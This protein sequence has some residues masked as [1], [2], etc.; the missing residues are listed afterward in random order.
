[1]NASSAHRA[2]YS[3][4]A[5]L[6]RRSMIHGGP[7]DIISKALGTVVA[8]IKRVAANLWRIEGDDGQAIEGPRRNHLV[9]EYVSANEKFTAL[10]LTRG[11]DVAEVDTRAEGVITLEQDANKNCWLALCTLSRT[12]SHGPIERE[13]IEAHN[14]RTKRTRNKRTRRYANLGEMAWVV[15]D[16][17][18]GIYAAKTGGDIS[19]KK[20]IVHPTLYARIQ[21]G[22]IIETTRD[23]DAAIKWMSEGLTE[24]DVIAALRGFNGEIVSE[25]TVLA[26]LNVSYTQIVQDYAFS[27]GFLDEDGYVTV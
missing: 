6:S 10:D 2:T 19:Y 15:A 8:T 18:D 17:A 26:W 23:E 20:N 5:K 3:D 24:G 4:H 16:L 25:R 27:L 21:G 7:C 22:R 13:F 12:G 14:D 9:A 1:M 11:D